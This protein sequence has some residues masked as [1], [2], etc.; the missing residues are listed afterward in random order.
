MV[1]HTLYYPIQLINR[2]ILYF[3]SSSSLFSV[4]FS[5]FPFLFFFGV[6]VICLPRVRL[7]RSSASCD[8]RWERLVVHDFNARLYR[9]DL[10]VPILDLCF[11]CFSFIY[12]YIYTYVYFVICATAT[13]TAALSIPASIVV[14]FSWRCARTWTRRNIPH[15]SWHHR[16]N[17]N[18]LCMR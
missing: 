14:R 5:L 8:D 6:I 7:S 18:H 15:V 12:I 13:A 9:T 11:L 4:S 17:E 2:F 1:W 10:A 16:F 3:L